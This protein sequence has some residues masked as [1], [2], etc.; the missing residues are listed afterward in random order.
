MNPGA[1]QQPYQSQPQPPYQPPYG[2]Q[3]GSCNIGGCQFRSLKFVFLLVRSVSSSSC[4]W[5]ECS[6]L[7]RT[8][9]RPGWWCSRRRI[10]SW[11]DFRRVRGCVQSGSKNSGRRREVPLRCCIRVVGHTQSGWSSH[12]CSLLAKG[13]SGCTWTPEQGILFGAVQQK[14]WIEPDEE[15]SHLPDSCQL[16]W[17]NSSKSLHSQLCPSCC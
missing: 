3:Q 17:R 1:P 6:H 13:S 4:C 16:S 7:W 12:V 2:F 5:C 8:S 15:H 14:G 10:S 11:H 9:S